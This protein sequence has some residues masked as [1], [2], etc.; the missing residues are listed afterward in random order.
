ME[1]TEL[2]PVFDFDSIIDINLSVLHLLRSHYDNPKYMY[3]NVHRVDDYFLRSEL[4]MSD[5]INPLHIFMKPEY[6][7]DFNSLYE[8]LLKDP[9]LKNFY[10]PTSIF[11]LLNIYHEADYIKPS[12]LCKNAQEQHHISI[13]GRKYKKEYDTILVK[14]GDKFKMGVHDSYYTGDIFNIDYRLD[15]PEGVSFKISKFKYNLES[16]EGMPLPLASESIKYVDT[17]KFYLIDPY[18]NFTLPIN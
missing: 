3:S 7:D 13:L 17:N 15:N 11:G 10:T 12:I 18:A 5:T 9:K 4:I 2:R 14:E 8:E 1:G 16:K 6:K